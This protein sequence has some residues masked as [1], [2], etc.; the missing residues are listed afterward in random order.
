V[1]DYSH[2]DKE[3]LLGKLEKEIKI[4]LQANEEKWRQRSRAIWVKSG[5][6]NTNF[7]HHFA[8]HRCNRKHIWEIF[9]DTQQRL[10]GQKTIKEEVLHYYKNFFKARSSSYTVKQV[11]V[12]SIFSRMVNIDEERS[13]YVPVNLEEIK[14]VLALFKKYKIPGPDG[15]TVEFFTHF[16]DLVG[17]YILE[18]IEE[19]RQSGF[20]IG[21][22]N[23][24]FL[25]L[26]PKENKPT[27]FGDFQ[28]ISLCNLC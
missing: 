27:N 9:D 20:I 3:L 6:Q 21:S 23:S 18:M 11:Q 13:L 17:K 16:F 19:S 8:N 14:E 25:A 12:T 24:T 26:I 10:T 4:I 7:F 1:D 2:S 15:W 22:L 28:P 5:D